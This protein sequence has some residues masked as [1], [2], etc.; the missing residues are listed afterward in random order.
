MKSLKAAASGDSMD[1]QQS[2]PSTNS[3]STLYTNMETITD[4]IKRSKTLNES[5][6][7][8]I[9]KLDSFTCFLQ[10]PLELQRQI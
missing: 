6:L 8:E 1:V 4:G 10:L 2:A 3:T 9:V 7:E 5:A